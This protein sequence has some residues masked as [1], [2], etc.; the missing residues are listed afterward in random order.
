MR[1]KGPKD[2]A[3]RWLRML[4]RGTRHFEHALGELRDDIETGRGEFTLA[5][6]G[7]SEEELFRLECEHRRSI[8]RE[9]IRCLRRSCRDR[10][11]IVGAIRYQIKRG[12]FNLADFDLTEGTL[13]S[14]EFGGPIKG[15]TKAS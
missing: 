10:M 4:R 14:L 11:H 5:N 7:T 13:T 12:G 1:K 9:M 8:I 2:S 15:H 6:I 3:K